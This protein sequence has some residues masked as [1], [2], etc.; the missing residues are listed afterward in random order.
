M[1]DKSIILVG[2]PETG[3][4]NYIGRLWLAL[5]SKK[6]GLV[7]TTPPED[8][9][10]VE[11]VAGHLLRGSFAPRTEPNDVAKEFFV[12][13]ESTDSSHVKANLLVPDIHGEIWKKAV[14]TLELPDSWFKMLQQSSGAILFLRVLS[15]LNVE[16]V[17]WVASQRFM[18]DIGGGGTEE[19]QLPTQV[20]LIELLRFLEENMNDEVKEPRVAVVLSAW[21]MLND[22]DAKLGPV[23]FI[24]QQFPMLGGRLS[25]LSR[26]KVKVFGLSIVGGNFGEQEFVD[27]ALEEGIQD[28]G[29]VIKQEDDGSFKRYDDI[30]EPIRWLLG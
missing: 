26:L 12:S 15:P 19:H 20:T 18:R 25:D 27:K 6:F 29:Y 13:V 10:Y 11:E 17:D 1:S 23:G 3:K 24:K 28:T 8:I 2:G 14:T 4:S 16:P 5:K 30:T 21:D 22:E 7:S 9:K